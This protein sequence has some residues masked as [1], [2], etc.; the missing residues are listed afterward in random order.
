MKKIKN[1]KKRNEFYTDVAVAYG[2]IGLIKKMYYY[3]SNK[4]LG[5]R[6]PVY[7]TTTTILTL[8]TSVGFPASRRVEH[9]FDLILYI[10]YNRNKLFLLFFS[11]IKFH[12]M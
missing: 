2:E 3:C 4:R 10:Q 5:M 11:D 1:N 8:I 9:L 7:G 6:V 12:Q